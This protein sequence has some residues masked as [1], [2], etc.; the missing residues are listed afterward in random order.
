M[1]VFSNSSIASGRS[2][3]IV[4]ASNGHLVTKSSSPTLMTHHSHATAEEYTNCQM[5]DNSVSHEMGAMKDHGGLRGEKMRGRRPSPCLTTSPVTVCECGHET[6]PRLLTQTTSSDW[7]RRAA[8]ILL[9]TL[10]IMT[11][12]LFL[13]TITFTMIEKPAEE[14]RLLLI[15]RTME[16]RIINLTD[17]IVNGTVHQLCGPDDVESCQ[18]KVN[19]TILESEAFAI[20]NEILLELEVHEFEADPASDEIHPHWGF[21]GAFHFCITTITTI[22]YGNFAPETDGGRVLTVF[23]CLL[24]IPLFFFLCSQCCR[25]FSYMFLKVRCKVNVSKSRIRRTIYYICCIVSLQSFIFILPVLILTL[26]EKMNTLSAVYFLVATLTTVGYGD[27]NPL[28]PVTN[29]HGT[30]HQ[31]LLNIGTWVYMIVGLSLFGNLIRFI[32]YRIETL[33]GCCVNN[34]KQVKSFCS[35]C[36]PISTTT[37][38]DKDSQQLQAES[39]VEIQV[40]QNNRLKTTGNLSDDDIYTDSSN[41]KPNQILAEKSL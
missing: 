32:Q 30:L 31:V 16:S 12:Y 38:S 36:L 28:D 39:A 26:Q 23:Y 11:L 41:S 21:T 8:I 35:Q 7:N 3:S 5:R 17:S 20:M 14:D 34:V 1:A 13:G 37:K 33:T 29:A 40:I 25:L 19:F 15:K 9:R 4:T 24:G 18:S 6:K 10:F 22:G 27:L 2:E